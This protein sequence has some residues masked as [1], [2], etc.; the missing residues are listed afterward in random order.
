MTTTEFDLDVKDHKHPSGEEIK[1]GRR[2]P[3][4]E[5]TEQGDHSP[6]HVTKKWEPLRT[7]GHPIIEETQYVV[8]PSAEQTA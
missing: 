1:T 7:W 6:N 3:V 4:G 5:T 8:R 2:I